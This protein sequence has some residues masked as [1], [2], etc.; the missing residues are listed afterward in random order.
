MTPVLDSSLCCSNTFHIFPHIAGTKDL[1]G[2]PC[3]PASSGAFVA[4]SASKDLAS[5]DPGA[6]KSLPSCHAL[7]L[8]DSWEDHVL[9]R[10]DDRLPN[11]DSPAWNGSVNTVSKPVRAA[12]SGENTAP[13]P[14]PPK[15]VTAPVKASSPVV[16][17]SSGENTTPKPT[18]PHEVPD[19]LMPTFSAIVENWKNSKVKADG[20]SR[21]AKLSLDFLDSM[22]I[23]DQDRLAL[24]RIVTLAKAE[25]EREKGNHETDPENA[26]LPMT[27]EQSDCEMVDEKM[28]E[29]DTGANKITFDKHY[30]MFLSCIMSDISKI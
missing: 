29:K 30:H 14:R 8:R 1:A 26:S 16:P 17:V 2:V 25:T 18:P 23:D 24:K 10:P 20:R 22:D 15:D 12:S 28:E 13:E 5:A 9:E 21:V 27:P 6:L 7:T 19:Y 11:P 3:T 4:G